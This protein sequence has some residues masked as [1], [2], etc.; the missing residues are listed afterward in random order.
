MGTAKRVPAA[1]DIPTF[2]EQGLPGYVVEAWFA[3]IGPKGMSAAEVKRCTTPSSPR[4]PT[5]AV[6]EAMAK[7]GNVINVVRR[8]SSPQDFFRTELAKYAAIVQEGGSR[9]AVTA[10]DCWH[11]LVSAPGRALCLNEPPAHNGSAYMADR[12]LQVFHA[13]AKHLSFTKAAEALFMTQPA[14]TF[15]IRQLEERFNTRLF[16]RAH[17]ASSRSRRA[18]LST[19]DYAE[20]ILALSAELDAR[21][22]ELTGQVEGSLLIGASTTI[23]DFLLPQVLGE[24]K[25]RFPGRDAEAFRRQL[26]SGAGPDRRAHARPRLHRG[27]L[28]PSDARHRRLLRRRAAGRV[29]ALASAGQ[30]VSGDPGIADGARLHQPR[31]GIANARGHR[32]LPAE[33]R[34]R[35]RR[36]AGRD[37][38]GQP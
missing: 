12:R 31:V 28:A 36:A 22:K 32:P 20:R 29:R 35:A 11:R 10:A 7:Q 37:G 19:L 3:V 30:A 1:P 23:A 9:A 26:G 2:V 27:R 33:E 14:V 38:G 24:F 21:L 8:A 25:A 5:P 16:D 4:S 18:G 6:K 13:V 34:R 17:G 15:Q